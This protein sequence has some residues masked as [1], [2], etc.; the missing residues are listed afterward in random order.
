MTNHI[1]GP[2]GHIVDAFIEHLK[3]MTGEQW[4]A[5]RNAARN[6]AR[7]AAW[8][9]AWGAA[10]DAAWDAAWDAVWGAASDAAWDAAWDAARDA[11]WGAA[12]AANEIQG[13]DLLRE[14]DQ[15]FFFLPLFGFADEQAVLGD[16]TNDQNTTT[17]EGQVT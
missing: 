15:P 3:G 7:N 5:A 6:V 17:E 8:G 16:K 10:S 12:G 14:R 11:A 9:A 2:N 1:Y 13:A 4:D